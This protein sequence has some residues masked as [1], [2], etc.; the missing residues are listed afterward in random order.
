MSL[1]FPFMRNIFNTGR[2]PRTPYNM[3]FANQNKN[4]FSTDKSVKDN[5]G[6][7]VTEE[8]VLEENVFFDIF[9]IR[10]YYE[11]ILLISLIFFLYK[12][13]V[14]DTGLFIALIMLLLS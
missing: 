6:S 1:G 11:D 12:E 9:G 7:N 2:M 14:N 10:L 8:K 3:Q 13:G 5:I 4:N